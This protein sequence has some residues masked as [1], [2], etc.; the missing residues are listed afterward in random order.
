MV[1]YIFLSHT[2]DISFHTKRGITPV[3]LP[4]TFQTWT[5]Y[6]P[7]WRVS[8]G[9]LERG[10]C[11][12]RVGWW[13]S[14]IEDGLSS[15]TRCYFSSAE[16]T[17]L[18]HRALTSWH[19]VAIKSPSML[20]VLTSRRNS[21]LILYQVSYLVVKHMVWWKSHYFLPESSTRWLYRSIGVVTDESHRK[22]YRSSLSCV[23]GACDHGFKSYF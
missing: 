17:I 14:G 2:F 22:C 5:L 3:S 4:C 23:P 10:G 16:K 11:W 1:T 6:R 12:R 8:R 9:N 7:P 15:R 21:A 20:S 18:S 13:R 19:L